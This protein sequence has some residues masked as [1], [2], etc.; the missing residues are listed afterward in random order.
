MNIHIYAISLCSNK[1]LIIHISLYFE[2]EEKDDS[3]LMSCWAQPFRQ[4]YSLIQDLAV[5]ISW[6][7]AAE[8]RVSGR[9]FIHQCTHRPPVHSFAV[10]LSQ[11]HLWCHVLVRP[12]YRLQAFVLSICQLLITTS[13]SANLERER[14]HWKSQ[15]L[16]LLWSSLQGNNR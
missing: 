12:A 2:I 8:R 14:V 13:V 5:E 1:R 10:P 3:H 4:R 7:F 16:S 9:H 11:D 6:S 15:V